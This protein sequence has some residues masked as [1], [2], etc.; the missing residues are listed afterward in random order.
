MSNMQL[1]QV[2]Q[3]TINYTH[4]NQYEVPRSVLGT[5]HDAAAGGDLETSYS[6]SCGGMNSRIWDL[7]MAISLKPQKHG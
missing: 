2:K 7:D 4:I 3:F 6:Y 5:V 1:C